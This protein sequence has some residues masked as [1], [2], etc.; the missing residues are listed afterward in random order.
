MGSAFP[1]PSTYTGGFGKSRARSAEVTM[2]AP[3]ASVT[4]QQSSR[5]NGQAIMR[6]RSTSS[7]VIGSRANAFGLSA[8]HL[9]VATATS[10]ICSLLVPNSCMCRVAS[11]P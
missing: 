4:R 6:E 9:R 1:V 10:A 3:P 5:L 11:M 7:M 8:A 2:Q